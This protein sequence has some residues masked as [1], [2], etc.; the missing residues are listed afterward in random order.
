MAAG[1]E[2]MI[3]TKIEGYLINLALTYEEAGD[4]IWVINDEEKGLGSV[5]VFAEEGL[6]TIR[7]KVMDLPNSQRQELFEEL[8]RL[9]VDMVHGAYALDDNDVILIETFEFSTL[10]FEEFQAAFDAIGLELSEHYPRLSSYR[11]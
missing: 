8:L 2:T 9:N 1:N 11:A 7:A 10:D 4:N 6:V 5:V 3:K